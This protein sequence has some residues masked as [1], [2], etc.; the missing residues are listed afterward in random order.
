[1]LHLSDKASIIYAVVLIVS[2]TGYALT[3]IR[4]EFYIT[5]GAVLIS[6]GIMVLTTLYTYPDF[7]ELYRMGIRTQ[8]RLTTMMYAGT[9]LAVVS[10]IA[11]IVCI[12]KIPVHT[13]QYLSATVFCMFI[14][15][16]ALILFVPSYNISRFLSQDSYASD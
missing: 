7:A 2:G 1:M 6:L 5:N 15:T 10:M 14:T 11:D 9:L 8:K 4:D 13:T 12:A 3:H 16:V